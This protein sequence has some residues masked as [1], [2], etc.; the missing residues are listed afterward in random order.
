MVKGGCG[1]HAV[2]RVERRSFQLALTVQ[3]APAI[4]DRVC[5]GQDAVTKPT[6]QVGMKPRL[7]L[8]AAVAL[9]K[10]DEPLA[11]FTDRDGTEEERRHG[12]RLEPLHDAGLQTVPAEF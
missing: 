11:Y 8:G 5:D 3:H 4:G 12:L 9:R 7:Q 10:H 6:Q 2:C 1:N